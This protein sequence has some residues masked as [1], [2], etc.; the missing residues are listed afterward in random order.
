MS[1]SAT[2]SPSRWRSLRNNALLIGV[3]VLITLLIRI[4]VAE[5]RFIPSESMEPTLWP[6]D[7]I[8]VEKITY[9]QRS[10]QP[11]DIVVFYTPPLLQTLGYRADQALIKRVIATAGDTVA[12]HDGQVWVNDRPL[13]EPYIAEPPFY[14]L[15]PVTVPEN[16][17]FVMGDNRNHSNDS[18]IWGFLPLENVIGRAIACYWPLNHAGKIS[19]PAA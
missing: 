6:G 1:A 19:S 2:N 16:M 4:F 18:H 3:A 15:S 9:R 5:S 14:T 10:P 12:V 17:L 7:R 11:G 8:V 13:E